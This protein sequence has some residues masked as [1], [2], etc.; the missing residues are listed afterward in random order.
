MSTIDLQQL[1]QSLLMPMPAAIGSDLS[2]V[3]IRGSTTHRLAKDANGLPCLLI[4]QPEQEQRPSP[5]RLE[6]LQVSFAVP[7]NVVT[8]NGQQERD[9]FTI[10]RCTSTPDLFPHFLRI[11]SPL[12]AGPGAYAHTGGDQTDRRRPRRTLPGPH[13]AH[14]QD[15]PRTLG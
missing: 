12:V 2:A 10:V 7:C 5:I 11:V 9:T 13:R 15:D 4:R 14:P 3:P 1:F 6:N 8:P